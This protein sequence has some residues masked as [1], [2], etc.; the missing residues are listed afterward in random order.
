MFHSIDHPDRNE[1]AAR[2]PHATVLV[3]LELIPTA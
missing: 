2:D 1:T 3:S